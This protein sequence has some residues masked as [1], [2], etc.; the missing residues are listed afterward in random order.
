M[1]KLLLLGQDGS[2]LRALADAGQQVVAV[3][4]AKAASQRLDSEEFDLLICDLSLPRATEAVRKARGQRAPPEVIVVAG[5]QQMEMALEAV[6]GGACDYLVKPIH[7]TMLVHVVERALAFRTLSATNELLRQYVALADAARRIA[8]ARDRSQ[9]LAC[10]YAALP[11]LTCAKRVLIYSRTDAHCSLQLGH[12]LS[13]TEVLRLA[14]RFADELR[15]ITV[16]QAQRELESP[17]EELRAFVY[18]ARESGDL[19]HFIV[20][21]YDALPS[22]EAHSA[23]HYIGR[24]LALGADHVERATAGR[25]LAF[26]DHL[27]SLFNTRYLQHSLDAQMKSS[28]EKQQPFSLLFLDLDHF[29]AIN[30]TYGHA[31]GSAALVELARLLKACVR[32][33]DTVVR[34]GGDEFVVLLPKSDVDGAALVAERI[35]RR[36]AEHQFLAREGKQ[37]HM[38]TCIGIASYPR[39]AGDSAGLLDLADRAMYRGKVAERGLIHVAETRAS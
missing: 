22:E 32:D 31:I 9:L 27:T 5:P 3:A 33:T 29:K 13:A 4:D 20:C 15:P 35:R 14:K 12:S 34:Y 37:L 25:E 23:A 16:L 19:T 21:L 17:I 10:A 38:T 6:R 28:Q 18:P 24:S 26:K 8:T 2:Q 39:H 11:A 7:E 30:D 1:S 36:V